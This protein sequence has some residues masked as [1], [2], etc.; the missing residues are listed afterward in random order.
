M[1][2]SI[3]RDA[4]DVDVS[5]LSD[6]SLYGLRL[7]AVPD[8]G[9]KRHRDTQRGQSYWRPKDKKGQQ[10]MASYGVNRTHGSVHDTLAAIGIFAV[11]LAAIVFVLIVL[12]WVISI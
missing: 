11:A 4:P 1:P 5:H 6:R 7:H 10:A 8:D 9:A 2:V 3:T 12:P